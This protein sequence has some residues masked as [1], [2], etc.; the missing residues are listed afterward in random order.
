VSLPNV[1][2]FAA[3]IPQ[4][5][6]S[7][8]SFAH[9]GRIITKHANPKTSA[10]QGVVAHAAHAAGVRPADG[11][12]ALSVSL[13]FFLPRPRSHYGSGKN[14]AVLKA[15]APRFPTGKPDVD[16]LERAC[17]DALTGVG[18]V[19]DSQVVETHPAKRYVVD[20][21]DVAGVAGVLVRVEALS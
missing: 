13:T 2:F 9:K 11:G 10:W 12:V 15:T 17:L 1:V 19:D 18:Y 14:A 20:G 8:R 3:G 7:T 4:T 6:G 5:K 21:H 16:K